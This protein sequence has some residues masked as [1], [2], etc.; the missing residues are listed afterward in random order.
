MQRNYFDIE[1]DNQFPCFCEA[2]LV[3]KPLDDMSPDP[4]YCLNCFEFLTQE[5]ELITGR[6]KWIPKPQKH[7][8]LGGKKLVRVSQHGQGIMS[9][10]ADEKITVDII[11]ASVSKKARFPRGRKKIVLPKEQIKRMLSEGYGTKAIA[12]RLKREHEITVS[13]KTIQRTIER[14]LDK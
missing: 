5:A 13:Y 9:T 7:P 11:Q 10:L 2:C 1:R 8:K 14:G 3:G 12:T 6:P 4:R